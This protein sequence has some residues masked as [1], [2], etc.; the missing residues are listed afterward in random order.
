MAP[1]KKSSA[2]KEIVA[3]QKKIV[4]RSA[5]QKNSDALRASKKI[6]DALRASKK[7]VEVLRASKKNSEEAPGFPTILI[8]KRTSCW[9]PDP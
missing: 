3:P 7:I 2:S 4:R 1:Q 6:V 5:P 8:G 9:P